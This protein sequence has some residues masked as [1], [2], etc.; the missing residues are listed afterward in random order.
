MAK[1]SKHYVNNKE[2]LQAISEW[3]EKVKE[4]FSL[5]APT[6]RIANL[7]LIP[8]RSPIHVQTVMGYFYRQA[9][10]M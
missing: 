3:K 2:F 8:N 6:I 4:E 10:I 7:Q 5:V 1:Q 9:E